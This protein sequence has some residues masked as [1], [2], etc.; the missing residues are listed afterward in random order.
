MTKL[1]L[2]QIRERIEENSQPFCSGC[3]RNLG[4]G[5]HVECFD[6][7][8]PVNFRLERQRTHDQLL[9]LLYEWKPEHG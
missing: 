5:T 4:F 1:T 7:P 3:G 8:S 2:A 9:I 6:R